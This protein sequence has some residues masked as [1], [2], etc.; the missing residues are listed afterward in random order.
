M[1]IRRVCSHAFYAI[2]VLAA[3]TPC[4]FAQSLA[5]Q[6]RAVEQVLASAPQCQGLGDLYW[7]IGNA[8]G[9]LASGQVGRA[10]TANRV[11]RLASAS[12]WV[13]GAYVLEKTAGNLTPTQVAALEMQ[14]GY[15]QM[16]PLGCAGAATI[17]ACLQRGRNGSYN[18]EHFGKFSYNGGHDQKLAHDLGLGQMNI[19]A[20]SQDL[21]RT[22]G[23]DIAYAGP[24]PAGG[25]AASPSAYGAF[26][27]KILKDELQISR[28]LG[29]RPVCTLPDSCP[30]AV[31]SPAPYAWHYSLNHWVEDGPGD[32]GAFSSAGLFGFYPWIA[33]D[34]SSYGI[35]ARLS[36][37]K[38][39]GMLSAQC[40]AAIRQVWRTAGK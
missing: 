22:L 8:D 2:G 5:T 11:I 37:S 4:L 40:G 31:S 16:H 13:F 19:E 28:L 15:D 32:D 23:V 26:L 39:A 38:R 3:P 27:R 14:S 21:Q 1:K 9:V 10:I 36:L 12:K 29:N 6:V 18:R 7:E 30:Q 25:M 17:D 34:R 33:A 24:Q 35:L 20:L